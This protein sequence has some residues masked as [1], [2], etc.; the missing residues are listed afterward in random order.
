[1]Q[2]IDMDVYAKLKT[3]AQ[4]R[5]VTVQELV[6]AVVLPDWMKNQNGK[7]LKAS[8]RTRT[9]TKLPS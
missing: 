1:M 8:S 6:R 4:E 5:G 9:R 3:M 7:K 2:T